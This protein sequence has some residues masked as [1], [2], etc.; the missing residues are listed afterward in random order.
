MKFLGFRSTHAI[1]KWHEKWDIVM[2][3]G[4]TKVLQEIKGI[5]NI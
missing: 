5:A 2:N 4:G 1:C 3:S